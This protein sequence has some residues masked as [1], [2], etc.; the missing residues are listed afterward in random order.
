MISK[1]KAANPDVVYNTLNGDSNVAFFKQLKDA[2]FTAASCTTLSVSVAEEEVRGIGA[3]SWPAPGGL[4]LLPDHRDAREQE[5]RR[6][7]TRRSSAP[8]RVTDDPI[9][10]G[11]IGVY[12]WAMAVKKA[13]STDVD[14]VR[15]AAK[16]LEFEAPEGLVTVD[17]ENQHISKTVRIGKDPPGRPV[18]GDLAHAQAGRAGPVPRDLHLGRRSSPRKRRS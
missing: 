9:E 5:V 6:R 2:G 4:E 1:I 3:E 8:N 17:G 16:G 7:P 13:G 18:R 15:A 14:K 12:L 10:A 11:Y